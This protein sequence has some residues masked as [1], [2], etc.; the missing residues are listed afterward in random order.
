MNTLNNQQKSHST[1]QKP[2]TKLALTDLNHPSFHLSHSTPVKADLAPLEGDVVV[3]DYKLV[4]E[5]EPEI[6][7]IMGYAEFGDNLEIYSNF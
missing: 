3:G 6:V 4:I 2:V 7:V 1:W 5:T